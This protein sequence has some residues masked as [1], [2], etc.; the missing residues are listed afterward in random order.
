[1]LHTSR[2]QWRLFLLALS[3][4]VSPS[5]ANRADDCPNPDPYDRERHSLSRRW[6]P[7]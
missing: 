7:S 4:S 2:R 6:K 5:S 3:L 1:M